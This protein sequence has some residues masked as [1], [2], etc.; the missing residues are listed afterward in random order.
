MLIKPKQAE[1][2]ILLGAR[3]GEEMDLL[4]SVILN[5]NKLVS[6]YKSSH[7]TRKKLTIKCI[8]NLIIIVIFKYFYLIVEKKN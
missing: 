4:R 3:E 1:L 5:R 2:F 6:A 7:I 8:Q